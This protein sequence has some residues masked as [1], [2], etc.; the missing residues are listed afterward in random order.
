MSRFEHPDFLEW[1][2][3]L[4]VDMHDFNTFLYNKYGTLE[5]P[6]VTADVYDRE[7]EEWLWKK[8]ER[9]NL[10]DSWDAAMKFVETVLRDEYIKGEPIYAFQKGN[11]NDGYVYQVSLDYGNRLPGFVDVE[12]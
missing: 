11:E 3:G 12:L 2:D 10:F 1:T 4:V 8:Y 5:A 7:Y 9:D 6:T